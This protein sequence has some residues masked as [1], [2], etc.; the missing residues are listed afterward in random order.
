MKVLEGKIT[1]A[2]MAKTVVVEVERMVKHKLYQK[3]LRVTKKYKAHYEGMILNAGDRVKISSCRPLSK[4]I[5]YK[6]ISKL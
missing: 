4:D 2:K 1:S 6:V 3:I 5:H